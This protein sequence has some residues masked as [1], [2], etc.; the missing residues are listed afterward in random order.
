MVFQLVNDVFDKKA[1]EIAVAMDSNLSTEK[2]LI[3]V[4]SLY[5]LKVAV[6]WLRRFQSCLMSCNKS[7][8]EIPTS[9]LSVEDL[10]TAGLSLKRYPS[11]TFSQ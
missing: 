5:R 7:S 3:S 2:L 4:S 11:R 10:R 8:G 1:V 9:R 6:T